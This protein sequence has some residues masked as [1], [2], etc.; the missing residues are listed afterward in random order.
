MR[1]RSG[2]HLHEVGQRRGRAGVDLRPAFACVL[3][4]EQAAAQ[5]GDEHR[6]CV[7]GQG[8]E[9]RAAV[10]RGQG[11]PRLAVVV[12]AV[13]N[14]RFAGKIEPPGSGR[15]DGVEVEIVLEIAVGGV[16]QRRR[17][18]RPYAVVL[19]PASVA[20][21]PG[22]AAVRAGQEGAE[23]ADREAVVRVAEPDVE[24]RQLRLRR[25]VHE[26]PRC[27]AV[28]R[29]QDDRIV[30][31]RPAGLRVV[32][33][34]RGQHHLHRHL[35]LR[36][37]GAVVIGIQDVAALADHHQARPGSRS[38]EQ[39]GGRGEVGKASRQ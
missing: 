36:P 18:R 21:G 17:I 8:A 27:A 4:A 24:Q 9:P 15:H 2:L 23:S 3:G 20:A 16:Q 29:A 6:V 34:H 28:A 14:A 13:Q 12:G 7:Q 32:H 33:A 11:T 30:P 5:P 10:G 37:G 19:F 26:V 25:V 39:Q 35:C 38:V 22:V 31:D 1:I